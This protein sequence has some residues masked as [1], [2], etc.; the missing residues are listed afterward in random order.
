MS[1]Q[2]HEFR[3]DIGNVPIP[4]L[5]IELIERNEDRNA[6]CLAIC[7]EMG[8]E[9]HV[10]ILS[11]GLLDSV[12]KPDSLQETVTHGVVRERVSRTGERA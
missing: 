1:F 7:L 11:Y 2:L 9:T 12:P 5:N 4:R 8:F 6:F 10:E 3:L